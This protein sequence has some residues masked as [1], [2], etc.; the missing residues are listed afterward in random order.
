MARSRSAAAAHAAGALLAVAAAGPSMGQ[1]GPAPLVVC[2][3]A[4]NPP[5]S[6]RRDGTLRGLDLR[7]AQAAAQALGRPLEVLPFESA[8]DKDSTLAQDVA[9]LLSAGMCEAV[10]GFPLLAGDIGVVP[11]PNA[12]TPDTP[13]APRRRDRPF[14]PL[15]PLVA[16]KAYLGAALGLV[17]SDKVAAEQPG[18][19]SLADFAARPE[20]GRLGSVAGSM[21]S[22]VSLM[23]RFGALRGRSVSFEVRE[24]PFDALAAGRAGAVLAPLARFDGWRVRHPQSPLRATGWRR[25]LGINLGFVSLAPAQAVREAIDGVVDQTLADGRLA[26]WAAEE[27]VSWTPPIAPDVGRPPGLAELAAD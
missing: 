2:V 17:L 15:Q 10:S 26:A 5:L 22:A 14:I 4:D 16:G 1:A 23:W 11:R 7:I 25:P 18:L 3:A 20:A 13:G 8:Y 19:R 6:Y 27:G 9:A 12:R 21:A 24:D